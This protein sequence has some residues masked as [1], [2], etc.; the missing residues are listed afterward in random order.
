MY[1]QLFLEEVLLHRSLISTFQSLSLSVLKHK[2]KLAPPTGK[3][4]EILI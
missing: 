4:V 1:I 3:R 2:K